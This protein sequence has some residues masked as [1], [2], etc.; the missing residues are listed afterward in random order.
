MSNAKDKDGMPEVD[1]EFTLRV[2]GMMC[3]HCEARVEAALLELSADFAAYSDYP[4]EDLPDVE[5]DEMAKML[6]KSKNITYT[7]NNVKIM[8]ALN[9]ESM[10]LYIGS[11]IGNLTD[12]V[13]TEIRANRK[14]NFRHIKRSC[15]KCH[16]GVF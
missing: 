14:Y 16:Y 8:S 11:C 7:E 2:D 1:G 10:E 15:E 6:E 3:A 4:D 9:E 13:R 12:G 5:R